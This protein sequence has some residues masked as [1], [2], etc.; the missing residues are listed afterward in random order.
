[1][2]ISKI[3]IA[4]SIA[5]SAAPTYAEKFNCSCLS[6]AK[7]T[8]ESYDKES[9]SCTATF[10]STSTDKLGQ[11]QHN[12]KAYL[13]EHTQSD[14]DVTYKFRPRNGACLL[15]A[16]DGENGK[17]SAQQLVDPQW[18][19]SMCDDGNE[20]KISGFNLKNTGETHGVTQWL[21]TYHVTT[22]KKSYDGLS[23]YLQTSGDKYLAAF[24]L[25]D[26]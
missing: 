21:S 3:V 4:A 26:K 8:V 15:A 23:I 22:S 10:S 19:G 9:L 1:M 13:S 25:Q 16:Y 6:S 17:N 12:L 20:K 24:C 2:N 7:S 5:I 11:T 18:G 14:K